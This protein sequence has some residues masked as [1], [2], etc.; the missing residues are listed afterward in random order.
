V[1][2]EASPGHIL[3][4]GH[5]VDLLEGADDAA[6][7]PQATISLRKALDEMVTVTPATTVASSRRASAATSAASGEPTSGRSRA[8]TSSGQST[9]TVGRRGGRDL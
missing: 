7:G 3:A 6:V 4:E 5:A 1:R 8:I 2:E 9:R